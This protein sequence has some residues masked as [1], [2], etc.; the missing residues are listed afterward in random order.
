M[1]RKPPVVSLS[2]EFARQ[3][4]ALLNSTVCNGN[5]RIGV[6]SASPN[7]ASM[8]TGLRGTSQAAPVRLQT[9]GTVP[10]WLTFTCRTFINP[11]GYLTVES[12]TYGIGAGDPPEELLHYDY[13]RSKDDYPD[14]HMQ[15]RAG[16]AAW[17][18][19]LE[20]SG[21][22]KGSLHK[23]HL[24]VGGRRYRPALEDV[25]EMLILEG[26]VAARGDWQSIVDSGRESFRLRQLSA[27]VQRN[28][29]VAV[30]ALEGAGYVVTKRTSPKEAVVQIFDRRRRKK[31]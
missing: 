24:P 7:R 21:I 11:A 5:A 6:I 1:S 10:V 2:E 15:I 13:E 3:L 19:L 14:A 8:G 27:A 23:L 25:L 16:S 29:E 22:G 4:A 18:R 28:P 9:V 31:N 30:E 20:A 26:I 12:S 17:D